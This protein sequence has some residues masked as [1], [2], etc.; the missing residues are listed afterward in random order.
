MGLHRAGPNHDNDHTTQVQTVQLRAPLQ[1]RTK[2]LC[3]TQPNV[4]AWI[5]A[6]L[7]A[8]NQPF[9]SGRQPHT[10]VPHHLDPAC[11]GQCRP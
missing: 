10:L 8:T 11:T 7:L 2:L 1:C 3:T 6:H 5:G 9:Y 4:V